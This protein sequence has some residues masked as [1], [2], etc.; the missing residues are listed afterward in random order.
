MLVE[1]ADGLHVKIKENLK[2][3]DAIKKELNLIKTIKNLGSVD[4]Y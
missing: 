2:T 1:E 4:L 3:T